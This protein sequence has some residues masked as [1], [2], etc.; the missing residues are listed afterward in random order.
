MEHLQELYMAILNRFKILL[1]T[2]DENE[3]DPLTE[4]RLDIEQLIQLLAKE[5][6]VEYDQEPLDPIRNKTTTD[7]TN[8]FWDQDDDE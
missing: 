5:L 8:S 6:N 4:L 7:I 3:N 2:K 1:D